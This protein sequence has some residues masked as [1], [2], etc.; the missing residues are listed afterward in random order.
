MCLRRFARNQAGFWTIEMARTAGLVKEKSNWVKIP[1]DMLV[2]RAQSRLA[3]MV[4]P[5]LLAGLYT[6][7]ELIDMRNGSA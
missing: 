1:T 3:R 7:D 6:P 4:Y 5:D 2:A